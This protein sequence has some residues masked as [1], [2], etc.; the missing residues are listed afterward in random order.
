[1]RKLANRSRRLLPRERVER[2]QDK[3]VQFVRDVVGNEDLADEIDNLSLEEYADRKKIRL[4][5]KYQK[6]G[7]SVMPSKRQ[8]EERIEE[9]EERNSELEET[10]SSIS[11]SANSALPESDDDD[12]DEDDD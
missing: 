10:L 1:M 12:L 4:V 5:N 8:L 6:G 9:L 3:A 7:E 2:M 11:E